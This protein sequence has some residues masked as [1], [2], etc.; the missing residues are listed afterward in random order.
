VSGHA[1]LLVTVENKHNGR[2]L[3]TQYT[4]KYVTWAA[5]GTEPTDTHANG[6]V[7]VTLVPHPPRIHCMHASVRLCRQQISM[8][9][10]TSSGDSCAT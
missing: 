7:P 2:L 6:H 5:F 4:Q 3:T 9:T 8:F 10:S 1:V